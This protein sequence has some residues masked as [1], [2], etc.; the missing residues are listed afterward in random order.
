ML[1][2]REQ[3]NSG[4]MISNIGEG[5]DALMALCVTD[6]PDCC[7]YPYTDERFG[8]WYF[9]DGSLVWIERYG[10]QFYRDRGKQTVRLNRRGTR[11]PF[12]LTTIMLKCQIALICSLQDNAVYPTGIFHC[13]LPDITGTNRRLYMLNCTCILGKLTVS[14][15]LYTFN[16]AQYKI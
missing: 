2:Q 4:L 7:R 14:C 8:E 9:P 6:K 16:S 11:I 10:Y 5:E 1:L 15:Y 13:E 3:H 12:L